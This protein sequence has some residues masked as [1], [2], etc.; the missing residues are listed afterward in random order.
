M[1]LVYWGSRSHDAAPRAICETL[2]PEVRHC[3][4][5]YLNNQMEQDHRGIKQRS[6]PMRGFGSFEAAAR[7]CSAH[8]ERRDHVRFRHHMNETVSLA[9]QQRLFVEWWDTVCDARGRVAE[10]KTTQPWAMA[11]Q[12]HFAF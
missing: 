11:H 10:V 12:R 2:G 1:L 6:Y 9:E 4:S 7:F 3:T 8:D 5:R